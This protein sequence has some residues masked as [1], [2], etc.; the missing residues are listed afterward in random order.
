MQNKNIGKHKKKKK[1]DNERNCF[2]LAP[3]LQRS[4]RIASSEYFLIQLILLQKEQIREH[5]SQMILF[6][7]RIITKSPGAMISM[8]LSDVGNFKLN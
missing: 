5:I 4:D 6:G 1:K 2:E 8:K 7:D 3:S